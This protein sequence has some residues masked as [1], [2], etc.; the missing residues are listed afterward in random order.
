MACSGKPRTEE[1][2][3]DTKTVA[4]LLGTQARVLRRW[5]RSDGSTFTAVGSGARYEFTERD[6]A[7]IRTRFNAW[8]S[9]NGRPDVPVEAPMPIDAPDHTP[10]VNDAAVWDEEG[11]VVMADIRDPRVRE[12]VRQIAAEQERRLDIALIAAGLHLTQ[13]RDRRRTKRAA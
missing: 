12:R 3:M 13:M 4:T 11:A 9:A 5:L 8:Q 10:P 7:T 6:V 1:I 2:Q